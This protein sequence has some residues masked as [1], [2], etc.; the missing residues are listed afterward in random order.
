MK[1]KIGFVSKNN[2][3][4]DKKAFSGT[5][6]K[7]REA[8][9]RAGFQVVW[10]PIRGKAVERIAKFLFKFVTLPGTKF[11]FTT[12]DARINAWFTD[13]EKLSE[14]DML[15]FVAD[16]FALL[17]YLKTSLPAVAYIDATLPLLMNYYWPIRTR[18]VYRNGM[19]REKRG[20]DA[21]NL[22]LTA[23]DWARNSC[24]NDFGQSPDKVHTLEFGANVDEVPI[25]CSSWNGKDELTIFFSGVDWKRKGAAVAI[26]TVK[27]LNDKGLRARL[28]LAGIKEHSIPAI[29]RNRPYVD[30]LGFLNKNDEAQN[31]LYKLSIARAHLF[32][33]PTRAECSATVFAEASSAGLPIFSYLTGGLANYVVEGVN[34]H[35]LSP[36]ATALD[37]AEA[38]LQTINN[39]QLSALA[40]G[41]KQLACQKLSWSA[42]T[43]RF[44]ELMRR[45]F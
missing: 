37:F 34:G 11:R 5:N 41:G 38:I 42:W 21:V 1:K 32:L 7:V 40:E 36:G 14:C 33:L 24:I 27:A 3:F 30:Y 26:D 8:V 16:T 4:A 13:K 45:Y 20:L 15:L 23:S 12:F 6:Y 31:R 22:I 17:P 10:V 35:L 28:L 19:K 29:Y 43:T 2:P 39:G 18:W 25:A 9:E 44:A